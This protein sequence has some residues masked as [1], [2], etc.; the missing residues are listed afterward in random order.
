MYAL[1]KRVL[2]IFLVLAVI[3]AGVFGF[4]RFKTRDERQLRKNI[5]IMGNLVSKSSEDSDLVL[6][7]RVAKFTSYLTEDCLV[8]YG[9]PLPDMNGR[10]DIQMVVVNVQKIFKRLEV[11]G[12]DVTVVLS[13]NHQR[14]RTHLTV[15][16]V[17][18][19]AEETKELIDAREVDLSWIK[20]DRHW[21]IKEARYIQ[22]Q[23]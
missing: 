5:K 11:E 6:L 23:H 15:N 17:G 8:V 12:I 3:G 2:T 9:P 18:S 21:K 14:A 22:T 16:V 4:F 1:M 19:Q 20:I 7:A 10:E 13:A